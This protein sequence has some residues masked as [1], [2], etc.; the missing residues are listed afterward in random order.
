MANHYFKF[1]QFTV[2]QE[3]C[4]MK[5]CTDACLFG[6]LLPAVTVGNALDI[7][8]GTGLLS[9]MYA[10]NNTNIKID[11]IEIDTDAFEQ[12]NE[13]VSNCNWKHNISL[14]NTDIKI[15]EPNKKY[16]LIFSN[17]PFYS[18]DLKSSDSKKNMAMH[19][20]QLNYTDLIKS[21][22]RLLNSN[23]LFAVL[24]PFSAAAT[25]NKIATEHYLH[26]TRVVRV[27]QTENHSHFR[28]IQIFSL[29]KTDCKEEEITIKVNGEYSIE[30]IQL[31]QPFYLNLY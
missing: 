9:L 12:A 6:S 18:N 4:A 19:S 29:L 7:G 28:V 23:G 21:V 3:K 20:T 24:L 10:Q 13:N 15:F 22:V 25:F 17:P 11:A 8:A 1:K 14:Y 30:F 31:L 2:Q 16:E 26:L 27:K 5:V